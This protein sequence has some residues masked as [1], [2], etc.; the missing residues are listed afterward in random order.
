MK[1]EEWRWLLCG[2][3][4]ALLCGLWFGLLTGLT[5]A[6]AL[7]LAWEYNNH[8]TLTRLRRWLAAPE[9][10]SLPEGRGAWGD[11]CGELYRMRQQELLARS[12][13]EE[14]LTRSREALS[15]L[16]DAVVLLD[17]E[18]RIEWCN[19]AAE[20]L[21]SL[22]ADDYGLR[23]NQ[24]L[25]QPEFLTML[26]QPFNNE[27]LRMQTPEGAVL[28]VHRI[29]F[30]QRNSLLLARDVA[31]IEQANAML[32]DFVANISHELR[33]PLTVITGYLEPLTEGKLP[34]AE[35]LQRQCTQAHT[36][37]VRMG[38][39]VSDLLLLSRLERMNQ[40]GDE[41]ALRNIDM[42]SLLATLRAEAEA[43]SAGEHRISLEDEGPAVITGYAD[44]LHSAFANLVSNAVRYTPSGG[45]VQI[46]WRTESGSPVF[47]VT[48]SGPG[49]AAEHIPRLSERF[50]R[51]DRSHSSATGGTGL[52]LAIVNQVL[53][54]HQA[55]L[56]I[57]SSLGQG[58]CFSV[59]FAPEAVVPT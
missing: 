47:S 12:Q 40:N 49:I 19:Q 28:A 56:E 59:R 46:G 36:Q 1:P 33:T 48:D 30:G 14:S 32:K 7:L 51:V 16:P 37:A 44:E 58:S 8:R 43:L 55:A 3:A 10:S 4:A 9:I 52:G 53:L 42:P 39:L 18:L 41:E 13:L 20:R 26:A 29:P 15:A 6:L 21:L 11:L 27:Q 17:S 35:Q 34:P 25:R 31:Q 23:I 24:L 38:R 57:E 2:G 45:I 50:Y 22:S 54:H 5:L